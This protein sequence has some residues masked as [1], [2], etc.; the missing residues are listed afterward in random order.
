MSSAAEPSHIRHH[1]G[2]EA[3]KTSLFQ[4][5]HCLAERGA[6]HRTTTLSQVVA[7]ATFLFDWSQFLSLLIRPQWGFHDDVVAVASTFNLRHQLFGRAWLRVQWVCLA[8]CLVVVGFFAYFNSVRRRLAAGSRDASLCRELQVLRAGISLLCTPCY[9]MVVDVV[10]APLSCSEMQ[11]TLGVGWQ[12]FGGAHV[13]V[14][15]ACVLAIAVFVPHAVA[16]KLLFHSSDPNAAEILAKV[17]P[18][19]GLDSCATVAVWIVCRIFAGRAASHAQLL[20]SVFRHWRRSSG[21]HNRACCPAFACGVS[22]ALADRLVGD[23]AFGA[24]HGLDSHAPSLLPPTAE[25]SFVPTAFKCRALDDWRRNFVRFIGWRNFVHRCVGLHNAHLHWRRCVAA[26]L[27]MGTDIPVSQRWLS[28]AGAAL[29][30]GVLAC[31]L[32][33]SMHACMHAAY[34]HLC[35]VHFVFALLRCYAQDAFCGSSPNAARAEGS[36]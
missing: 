35:H 2:F 24:A 11:R 6:K 23:A 17:R 4:L 36:P 19:A 28:N 8:V 10:T 7:L 25:S 5:V 30:V 31:L 14:C 20:G 18:A 32:A 12:C 27:A 16:L 3:F 21:Q 34:A 13:A 26:T 22:L 1:G 33:C 29:L 15:V 9:T